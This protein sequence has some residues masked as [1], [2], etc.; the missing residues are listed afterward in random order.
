MCFSPRYYPQKGFT[1]LLIVWIRRC[2]AVCSKQTTPWLF[3]FLFLFILCHHICILPRW[4][5]LN[6]NKILSV[7]RVAVFLRFPDDASQVTS[8]IQ[9][10][11]VRQRSITGSSH[12]KEKKNLF[13]CC[14]AHYF[15]SRQSLNMPF[16]MC[17]WQMIRGRI[18]H[19]NKPDTFNQLWTVE[20]QVGSKCVRWDCWIDAINSCSS[21]LGGAGLYS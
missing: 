16:A 18:C 3:L 10:F 9:V 15:S 11:S 2:K 20:E 17:S 14:R 6:S 1:L 5:S 12:V 4:H 21:F 19:P 7:K 13:R 8:D